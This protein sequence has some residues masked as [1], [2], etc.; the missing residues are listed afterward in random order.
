MYVIE[1]TTSHDKMTLLSCKRQLMSFK[2]VSLEAVRCYFPFCRRT[3]ILRTQEQG[4][5]WAV[6][7]GLRFAFG[8]RRVLLVSWK[9]KVRTVSHLNSICLGCLL[10]SWVSTVLFF[11]V[12]VVFAVSFAVSFLF[13]R[14]DKPLPG[15]LWKTAR[16]CNS[17]KPF[18]PSNMHCYILLKCCSSYENH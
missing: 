16:K 9:I 11:H 4:D 2:K 15:H 3:S 13:P 10:S 12:T 7:W 8:G 6:S 17:H 5:A 18:L 14:C 1:N